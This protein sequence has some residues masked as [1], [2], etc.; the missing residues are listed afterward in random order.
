MKTNLSNISRKGQ[1]REERKRNRAQILTRSSPMSKK[2]KFS[3]MVESLTDLPQNVLLEILV[4]LP[5]K[6]LCASKC[7]CRTFL[8]LTSPNAQFIEMHSSNAPQSLAIQFAEGFLPSR[9][10]RMLEPEFLK[11]DFRPVFQV[12]DYA[13]STEIICHMRRF[14]SIQAVNDFSLVNSCNGLLYFVRKHA[15]DECSLVCNPVT[16]EY[17]WMIIAERAH[18]MTKSQWLGFDSTTNQYKVLRIS[19]SVRDDES[20]EMR[21][22]I[23]VLGSSWCRN[24]GNAPLG[25]DHSWDASFTFVNGVIYWFDPSQKN[26]VSFDF[27]KEMFG[28]VALPPEEHLRNKECVSIGVLGGCLA[29][30]YNHFLAH[31]LNIWVM[32]KHGNQQ[33]WSKKLV[34]DTPT[35]RLLIGQFKPL[36]ILK[37]GE[38]LMLWMRN[39]LVCY[40]PKIRRFRFVG[41]RRNL[42]PNIVLFNPSFIS[43]RDAMMVDKV[44]VQNVRPRYLYSSVMF[45]YLSSLLNVSTRIIL[46]IS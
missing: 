5:L 8:D 35:R 19:S 12:P 26:I 20:L 41:L 23:L 13:K 18:S 36:Q 2:Q 39:D 10:I 14:T 3:E 24:I 43:L 45:D 46:S 7:V 42:N 37:N 9:R 29:L 21:A 22:Q 28:N 40:N 6:T 25:F 17:I 38:L 30:S 11:F 44:F 27:Q 4:R 16:N 31:H 15:S 34:V 32:E 33:C 1:P